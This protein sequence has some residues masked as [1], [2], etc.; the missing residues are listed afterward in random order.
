MERLGLGPQAVLEANP[1]MVFGRMTGW[2]QDGP[3]AQT[4]G[5]DINYIALSGLL[6]TIGEAGRKPVVPLNLLG[7]FG[8]GGMLLA[9]GVI[10]AVLAVRNG[11]SGQ[12]VDAAMTEGSALLGTGLL[13]LMASGLWTEARGSNLLDGGAPWYDTYETADGRYVAVGAIEERFYG[14]LL[15]GLGLDQQEMPPRR[16]PANWPA[17]RE[18]LTMRFRTRPRDEWAAIFAD[19][20]ACVTPVLSL[21]EAREH[22]HMTSRHAYQAVGGILLPASAPRF[23]AV[24]S[25]HPTPAPARGAGGKALVSVWLAGSGAA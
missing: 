15:A 6:S 12:V 10:A 5:H 20:D 4:A 24:A 3:L 11:G 1:R 22:A 13:G 7:D 18:T 8:G 17:I 23:S 21:A 16:D 2:G 9:L 25:A 14:Q 19:G